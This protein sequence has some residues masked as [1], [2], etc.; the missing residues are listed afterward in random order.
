[1]E[2]EDRY[3]Q[4]SE[5]RIYQVK[6]ELA[7]I[8]QGSMSILEYYVKIKS[9]WDEQSTLIV[10]FESHCT[11]GGSKKD[12]HKLE[13]NQRMY[14]FLMGLNKSYANARGN[15]LMINPFPSI[16]RAYSLLVTDVPQFPSKSASFSVG[17]QK[18]FPPKI[19]F[20]PK[21]NNV[22]CS[23]YNKLGHTVDKCYKKHGFPPNFKFTKT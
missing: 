17:S 21:R 5:I 20:D 14:Q 3:G 18:S 1:M 13:E 6:K 16:N 8:S 11:C 15:L 2:L 10:H 9:V 12:I 22:V 4:P 7:S 19:M 23:Y